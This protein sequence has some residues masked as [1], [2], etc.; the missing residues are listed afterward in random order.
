M[1]AEGDHNWRTV[2]SVGLDSDI[3]RRVRD[4][5]AQ[6]AILLTGQANDWTEALD[7]AAGGRWDG[8]LI[9][10][11]LPDVPLSTVFEALRKPG[12]P[13]HSSGIVLLAARARCPEAASYV[14]RG[15]N[16]VVAVE[17]VEARL[18]DDFTQLFA[19]APRLPVQLPGRIEVRAAG[20]ARRLFCQTANVSVTGMLLRLPHSYRAGTEFAFELLFPGSLSAV[21]GKATV[22]RQTNLHRES[23][24]GVGVRF[25]AWER[26]HHERFLSFLETVQI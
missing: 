18:S 9:A 19:V 21:R 2:L 20:F 25:S 6:R 22:V 11:P 14:G 24:T 26:G 17:E 12:S 15:A 4:A 8:V 5:L 1:T 3:H 10:F 23:F 13:C 16:R 7:L